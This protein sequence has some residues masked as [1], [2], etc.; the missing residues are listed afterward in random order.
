MP[1]CVSHDPHAPLRAPRAP[2]DGPDARRAAVR[3]LS[4]PPAP[5]S[6]EETKFGPPLRDGEHSFGVA[7]IFASFNDTF[8]VRWDAGKV[9]VWPGRVALT[10]PCRG[11]G[12]RPR[13]TRST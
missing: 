1:R 13:A 12:P 4:R 7:H 2:R 3:S 8:V 10:A 5:Q 6:K 11:C 9:K